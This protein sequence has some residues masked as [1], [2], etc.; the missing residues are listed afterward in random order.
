MGSLPRCRKTS[1]SHYDN[2]GMYWAFCVFYL[3]LDAAEAL[4][5]L[6]GALTSCLI[7]HAYWLVW[8]VLLGTPGASRVSMASMDLEPYKRRH[9][10][11]ATFGH[12]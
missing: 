1:N 10:S 8:K 5:F 6:D 3:L 12:Y 11:K 4:R 2:S 7:T 9:P